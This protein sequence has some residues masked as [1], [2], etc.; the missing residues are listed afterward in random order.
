M[1]RRSKTMGDLGRSKTSSSGAELGGGAATTGGAAAHQILGDAKKGTSTSTRPDSS[2]NKVTLPEIRILPGIRERMQY[3]DGHPRV[4]MNDEDTMDAFRRTL[5]RLEK[6]KSVCEELEAHAK[7][8]ITKRSFSTMGGQSTGGTFSPSPLASPGGGQH[9]SR[10]HTTAN[11]MTTGKT[12][13]SSASNT[14]AGAGAG[15]ATEATMSS[16]FAPTSSSTT[17][18]ATDVSAAPPAG[19]A[20]NTNSTGGSNFNVAASATSTAS[21]FPAFRTTVASDF[22]NNPEIFEGYKKDLDFPKNEKVNHNADYTNDRARYLMLKRRKQLLLKKRQQLLLK[23]NAHHKYTTVEDVEAA[24]RLESDEFHASVDAQEEEI[25][26][27]KGSS[28]SPRAK[29]SPGGGGSRTPNSP[30]GGGQKDAIPEILPISPKE[31]KVQSVGQS[32]QEA[33][34]ALLR[35]QPQAFGLALS[36]MAKELRRIDIAN[37]RELLPAFVVTEQ[38]VNETTKSFENKIDPQFS[39]P[40]QHRETTVV[41]SHNHEKM[42]SSKVATFRA[43]AKKREFFKGATA[44]PESLLLFPNLRDVSLPDMR[45]PNGSFLARLLKLVAR[46]EGNSPLLNLTLDGNQLDFENIRFTLESN[47]ENLLHKHSS[48]GKMIKKAASG[49]GNSYKMNGSAIADHE[50][51]MFIQPSGNK[52]ALSDYPP[53][54]QTSRIY[55][56]SQKIL[57][58]HEKDIAEI[59][60]RSMRSW[61]K[62]HLHF[63]NLQQHHPQHLPHTPITPMTPQVEGGAG[64]SSS[65]GRHQ[66]GDSFSST[67]TSSMHNTTQSSFSLL[68][69]RPPSPIRRQPRDE[70]ANIARRNI[71][72]RMGASAGKET[73]STT[74]E[75]DEAQAEEMLYHI[76]NASHI[77]FYPDLTTSCLDLVKLYDK[78]K[79]LSL[80]RCNIDEQVVKRLILPYQSIEVLLLD[81]NPLLDMGLLYLMKANPLVFGHLPRPILKIIYGYEGSEADSD[82]LEETEVE[83]AFDFGEFLADLGEDFLNTDFINGGVK[84][85]KDDLAASVTEK[86][87]ASRVVDE[88]QIADHR[89][90]DVANKEILDNC[91]SSHVDI[92]QGAAAAPTGN[93]KN[94]AATGSSST[95]AGPPAT[96]KSSLKTSSS[97]TSTS[98]QQQQGPTASSS[99]PPVASSNNYYNPPPKSPLHSLSLRKTGL[100][101][102]NLLSLLFQSSSAKLKQLDLSRNPSLTVSYLESNTQPAP[103]LE[104][105]WVEECNLSLE[106]VKVLIRPF[107]TSLQKF[108]CSKQFDL[109]EEGEKKKPKPRGMNTLR[110]EMSRIVFRNICFFDNV[111][112]IPENLSYIAF[113]QLDLETKNLIDLVWNLLRDKIEIDLAFNPLLG[114]T[115]LSLLLLTLRSSKQAGLEQL[116]K[117]NSSRGLQHSSTTL[118]E[119]LAAGEVLEQNSENKN[120]AADESAN[121]DKTQTKPV[122]PSSILGLDKS[123]TVDMLEVG[124]DNDDENSKSKLPREE[125]PNSRR[126]NRQKPFHQVGDPTETNKRRR[127]FKQLIIRYEGCVYPRV[128]S[129]KQWGN[130][131]AIVTE[132]KEDF[133]ITVTHDVEKKEGVLSQK[134]VMLPPIEGGGDVVIEE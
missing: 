131:N 23:Q 38:V 121:A 41:E 8:K 71:R 124:D 93:I 36:N 85:E 72:I 115:G 133:G 14:N 24:V 107:M 62:H 118:G 61:Q 69:N 52:H 82:P 51:E 15:P 55:E 99:E 40:V 22:L 103:A 110:D 16:T 5:N 43:P 48:G 26:G 45:L 87:R 18:G 104:E 114:L 122:V 130:L 35:D 132:L 134:T 53:D 88:E 90:I 78:L 84:E 129:A 126:N 3:P 123:N 42:R 21:S 28:G 74:R 44:P 109:F 56:D 65:H 75:E 11:F 111:K 77:Q 6:S 119:I 67:A 49:I 105:L 50:A 95:G 112:N 59:S 27:G 127:K 13:T 34:R 60:G 37:L 101:A 81:E 31:E 96:L 76:A 10:A 68:H 113:K 91:S 79:Y 19:A 4:S 39:P 86:L 1:K 98:K 9:M 17:L 83:S 100:C 125:Y 58:D 29:G 20:F 66:K 54:K 70:L 106:Q 33:A 2:G 94:V 108:H 63:Q 102:G 64:S 30:G 117:M 25:Q 116:R 80:K 128:L 32:Q 73:K 57:K 120:P 47:K 92:S 89:E 12:S 46:N 7:K 97:S